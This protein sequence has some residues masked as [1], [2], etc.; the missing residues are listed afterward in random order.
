MKWLPCAFALAGSWLV[1][2]P[3]FA[4][5]ASPVRIEIIDGEWPGVLANS[6]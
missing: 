5:M 4:G 2:A 3:V 1:T 6:P